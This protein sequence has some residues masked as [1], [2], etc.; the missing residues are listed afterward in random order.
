ML[1]CLGVI[2]ISLIW[3]VR[4]ELNSVCLSGVLG[5]GVGVRVWWIMLWVSS[6]DLC[7]Y[8]MV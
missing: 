3:L 5:R 6:G 2:L 7:S 4:F 8:C 1:R